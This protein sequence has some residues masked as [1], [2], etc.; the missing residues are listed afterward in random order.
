MNI[1]K[2]DTK[3]VN[4]EEFNYLLGTREVY[5]YHIINEEN[6]LVTHSQLPSSKI[7]KEHGY[8]YNKIINKEF[9][10]FNEKTEF[11]SFNDVSIVISAMITSYARIYMNKVKLKILSEGG[12]ILYKDTD[13]IVTSIPLKNELIGKNLGQ[14]K[15]EHIAKRAYFI[16]NKTYCL[17]AGDDEGKEKPHIKCKG[18]ISKDLTEKDFKDMYFDKKD[19]KAN[20]SNT[21]TNYEK[22]YVDIQKI[23]AI[24]KH[25][26]FRKRAKILNRKGL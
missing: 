11:N 8:D 6:I 5:D 1:N 15:L 10:M 25:D 21:I 4:K 23:E 22:G 19:V 16:S 3:L 20:K 9:R 12:M 2:N 24:I 13:S 17:I 26:A 7:C 14:F 18:L